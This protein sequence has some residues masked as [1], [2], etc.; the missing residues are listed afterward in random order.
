M[1]AADGKLRLT[2]AADEETLLRIQSILSPKA[3]PFK[4]WLA[5]V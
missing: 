3:E 5:R 2:D 4:Q 1:P